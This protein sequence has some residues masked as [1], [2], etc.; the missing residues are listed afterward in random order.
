MFL[1]EL[2]DRI[3]GTHPVSIHPYV[4]L[5]LRPPG[6]PPARARRG[7]R[8]GN[9]RA[10]EDDDAAPVHLFLC[11]EYEAGDVPGA[12]AGRFRHAGGERAG[13]RC[14]VAM[15]DFVAAH[16]KLYT[17]IWIDLA[18]FQSLGAVVTEVILQCR[19]QDS[20]LPGVALATDNASDITS[21]RGQT[22]EK[23]VRRVFEALQRN[24]CIL[25]FDQ[26]GSFG[27]KQTSHHGIGDPDGSLIRSVLRLHEFLFELIDRQGELRQSK[28]CL[29]V[30][31][32]VLASLPNP[33]PTSTSRWSGR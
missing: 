18:M 30:G 22:G 32:P 19:K 17:P 14:S 27:L 24:R 12:G 1:V 28:V 26:V 16:A 15:S 33:R 8:P 31:D 10:G 3:T 29:T 20:R 11:G 23:A 7:G 13:D 5:P 21:G 2:H 9:S 4:T 6:L 25:A